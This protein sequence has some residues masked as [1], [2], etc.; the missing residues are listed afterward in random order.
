MG[1]TEEVN[2]LLKNIINHKESNKLLSTLYREIQAN[3]KIPTY[4]ELIRM[5]KPVVITTQ[6]KEKQ[7]EGDA[8]EGSAGSS[9]DLEDQLREALK[10]KEESA[11]KLERIKKRLEKTQKEHAE[12]Q[13]AQTQSVG[14]V[15]GLERELGA[16][17][18]DRLQKIR[19]EIISQTTPK[20]RQ[21]T[22]KRFQN[23]ELS[24]KRYAT[25]RKLV[26][27][28]LDGGYDMNWKVVFLKLKTGMQEFL[29]RTSEKNRETTIERM[30]LFY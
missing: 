5:V 29:G 4:V 12:A 24:T 2:E 6:P 27:Q 19:D 16:T 20:R 23:M 10:E 26:D 1:K 14:K 11:K 18:P 9:S 17:A 21:Q 30:E 15:Q 8:P 28:A 13:E 22:A 3:N 7:G 25:V